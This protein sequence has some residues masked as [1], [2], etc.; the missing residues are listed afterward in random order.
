M[1]NNLVTEKSSSTHMDFILVNVKFQ[2]KNR[3]KLGQL[4]DI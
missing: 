3:L 1:V 4:K 2:Y